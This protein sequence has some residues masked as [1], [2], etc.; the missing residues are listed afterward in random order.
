MTIVSSENSGI[1]ITSFS[2][3]ANRDRE[4]IPRVVLVLRVQ[5]VDERVEIHVTG[6]LAFLAE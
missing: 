4:V 3:D 2:S 5:D 1:T 6:V